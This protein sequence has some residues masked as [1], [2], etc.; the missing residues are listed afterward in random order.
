MPDCEPGVLSAKFGFGFVSVKASEY[1]SLK[2]FTNSSPPSNV[3]PSNFSSFSL[4][5]EITSFL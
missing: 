3:S 4:I 2:P 5:L 1:C